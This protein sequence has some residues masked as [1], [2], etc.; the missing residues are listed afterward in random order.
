MDYTDNSKNALDYW[1]LN[2]HG[3]IRQIRCRYRFVFVLFQK[4]KILLNVPRNLE[5]FG[6]LIGLKAKRPDKSIAFTT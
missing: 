5:H 1:L 6:L 3:H 2:N 4:D